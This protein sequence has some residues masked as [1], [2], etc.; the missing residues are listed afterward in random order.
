[1]LTAKDGTIAQYESAGEL[2]LILR[3]DRDPTVRRY[4]TQPEA[5][6]YTDENGKRRTYTPDLKIWRTDDT[7]ELHEVT[8]SKRRDAPDM[9]RRE[10]AARRICSERGWKYVVHTEHDL[11]QSTEMANLLALL[12]YRA[13][14]HLKH[15]VVEA[16]HRQ[17]ACGRRAPLRQ[18]AT[19]IASELDMFEAYVTSS[20]CHLLWHG[21]LLTD[22]TKL[23]F[24]YAMPVPTALIWLPGASSAPT[25][26]RVD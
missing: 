25:V 26:A 3:C 24:S 15:E 21:T 19:Q 18:C 11:P 1:V 12:C 6:A 8:R 7:I 22:L 17:L 10:E 20:L 13:T 2:A 5:L 23:L 16:V 14:A 4:V 9:Q